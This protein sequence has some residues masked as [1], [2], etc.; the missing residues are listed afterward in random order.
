MIIG[1]L[2]LVMLGFVSL[3]LLA[4]LAHVGYFDTGSQRAKK[5]IIVFATAAIANEL[6]LMTQGLSAM[7]MLGSTIYPWLLLG[8]AIWL[9]AGASM[10]ALSVSGKLR[11]PTG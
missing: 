5:G 9:F 1:Y 8:A 10:I 6:I 3:Y 7:L 11:Q 4:H 2:H